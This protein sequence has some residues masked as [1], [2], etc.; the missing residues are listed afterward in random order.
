VTTTQIVRWAELMP[1]E[2]LSRQ[3]QVP[4]VYLPLGLCEPHGHAAAF[5]LDT[6]KAEW[7]CEE[8]ARRF[9]GIVA[10]TQGY[11][12]HETGYHAPWLTQA[13]GDVNPRLGSVPPDVLLRMLL[14]Q[15]RAFVNAGFRGIVVVT[16]H[17]GNQGDLRLVATEVMRSR[18]VRIMTV[19]DPELAHPT[20]AADHAGSF[21]TSQL[22]HIRPDLV[23]LDRLGDIDSSPLGRFAQNPDAVNASAEHGR[24]ILEHSLA[25]LERLITLHQPFPESVETL[26]IPAT[27]EI[28][29][30]ITARR[31]EWATLQ[32]SDPLPSA[33]AS[34]AQLGLL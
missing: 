14:F 23:D 6:L 12:I 4:L 13:V 21:E 7:L 30:R 17:H 24:D 18:P 16:G 5:G 31:A 32:E 1:R 8:A 9:G 15:L 33:S 20:Y 22:L 3:G 34:A 25:Q 11:Q 26:T 28:W 27:E 10:P 19:S 29:Q 2:F